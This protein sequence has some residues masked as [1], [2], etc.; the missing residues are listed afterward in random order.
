MLKVPMRARAKAEI[1][2]PEEQTTEDEEQSNTA[3]RCY[4][5][6]FQ[7]GHTVLVVCRVQRHPTRATQFN[8]LLAEGNVRQHVSARQTALSAAE[9]R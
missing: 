6:L 7:L 1:S 3:T 5:A 8:V 9:S 4:I 2:H